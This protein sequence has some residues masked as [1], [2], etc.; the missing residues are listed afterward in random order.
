M[1]RMSSAPT[2][3]RLRGALRVGDD[4]FARRGLTRAADVAPRGVV[5]RLDDLARPDVDVARIDPAIVPFFT[6]TASLRFVAESRWHGLAALLWPA[7]RAALWCV[8]QFVLPLRRATVRTEVLALDAARDGRPDARGVIRRYDD[9]SVM[10]VVAY[11]T[12]ARDGARWMSASFPL[13]GSALCGHLRLV[14][15]GETHD[16]HL[17]VALTS[18]P[19]DARDVT[20]GVRLAVGPWSLRLPLGETL[21]FWPAS[22]SARPTSLDPARVRGA[23]LV[24][25]HAQTLFGLRFAT[26]R[27]WFIPE[28]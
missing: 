3:S 13:P 16:G 4:Y 26:H 24:A 28:G 27:Y 25:E 10:Q 21:S 1:S 22:S 18:R 11:A 17:T 14:A 6:D 23:T 5:D 8:G 19:A 20:S 2:M 9:G 7:V 15:T 12:Y